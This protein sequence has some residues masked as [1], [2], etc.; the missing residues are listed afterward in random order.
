VT[1]LSGGEYGRDWGIDTLVGRFN[2]GRL[3]VWQ[4]KFV[5]TW[6]DDNP[7]GEVRESFKSAVK[8]ATEHKYTI[9]SWTLCVPSI[10]SPEQQKWF[11]GWAARQRRATGIRIGIWNGAELRH[12]LLRDDAR[13]VRREYF[14]HTLSPAQAPLRE[15]EPLAETDDMAQFEDALFI[16]QL[17]AA[18]ETP[19]CQPCLRHLQRY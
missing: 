19:L 10:L 12:Q 11:D 15:L 16:R 3:A 5:L 4:C 1:T 17:R 7:Q 8:H 2:D 18:G 9:R 6:D 14:P 13:H